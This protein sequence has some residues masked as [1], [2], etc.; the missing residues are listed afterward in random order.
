MQCLWLHLRDTLDLTTHETLVTLYIYILLPVLKHGVQD[1][2]VQR[3]ACG[4]LCNRRKKGCES[5]SSQAG[6][7][8]TGIFAHHREHVLVCLDNAFQQHGFIPVVL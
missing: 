4:D 7:I 5:L 1:L 2:V 6:F 3:F 8:N